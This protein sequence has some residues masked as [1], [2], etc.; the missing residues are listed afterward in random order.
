MTVYGP[1][2]FFFF[3]IRNG[4]IVEELVVSVG[5]QSVV[6][7]LVEAVECIVEALG[8]EVPEVWGWES[9]PRCRWVGGRPRKK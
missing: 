1:T 4:N 8:V 2:F 3:F 5:E 6:D 9:L 7:V